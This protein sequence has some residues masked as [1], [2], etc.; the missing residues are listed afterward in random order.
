M[1]CV[2][3][4]GGTGTRKP[5]FGNTESDEVCIEGTIFGDF[6]KFHSIFG[7]LHFEKSSTFAKNE[8]KPCSTCLKFF[9]SPRH[10]QKPKPRGVIPDLSLGKC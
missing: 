1:C 8:E 3:I 4:S 2:I 9:I 5:M 10:F 6:S 7:A